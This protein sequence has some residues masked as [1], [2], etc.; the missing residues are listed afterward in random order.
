MTAITHKKADLKAL[1]SKRIM[2]KYDAD[3]SAHR[4]LFQGMLNLALSKYTL[5]ELRAW[6]T[7]L[8]HGNVE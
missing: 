3:P 5:R 7:I 6:F 1:I 4:L 8:T 2:E